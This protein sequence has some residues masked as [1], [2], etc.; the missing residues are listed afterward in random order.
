MAKLKVTFS[1]FLITCVSAIYSGQLLAD[2]D[3]F[4]DI[5]YDV[6]FDEL[7]NSPVITPSAFI[8]DAKNG[9]RPV[10]TKMI[11]MSLTSRKSGEDSTT[12]IATLS[13]KVSNIGSSGDDGTKRSKRDTTKGYA[14][15]EVVCA[16]NKCIIE[17]A[18]PISKAD[19]RGHVTVLK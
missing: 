8:R 12:H 6:S 2:V 15:L 18:N 1:V 17:N 10:P 4:F 16:R 5:W 13:Y 11:S 3:S 7:A 14:E 9:S 19:F